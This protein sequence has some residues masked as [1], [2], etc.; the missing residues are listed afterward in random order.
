[1]NNHHGI[2]YMTANQQPAPTAAIDAV[3][4]AYSFSPGSYAFEALLSVVQAPAD[5]PDMPDWIAEFLAIM[6]DL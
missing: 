6:E 2:E 5:R 3:K 1:L 4:Q